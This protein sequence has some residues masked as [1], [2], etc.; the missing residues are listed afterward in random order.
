M[1]PTLHLC[2]SCL[3]WM[4]EVRASAKQVAVWPD[5][6]HPNIWSLQIK[7]TLA[8]TKYISHRLRKIRRR[9]TNAASIYVLRSPRTSL[10]CL[11]WNPVH[12]CRI[13]LMPLHSGMLIDEDWWCREDANALDYMNIWHMTTRRDEEHA[14][15]I[16]FIQYVNGHTQMSAV[17]KW[18]WRPDASQLRDVYLLTQTCYL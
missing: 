13:R 12:P 18:R 8:I 9:C 6:F 2:T 11:I 7:Y 4:D 14:V 1:D 15:G 5:L 16:M 17:D 3:L 10:H